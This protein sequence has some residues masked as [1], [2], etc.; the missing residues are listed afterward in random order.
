[1]AARC[2]QP[3][4]NP[5][6][7]IIRP[8]SAH[9]VEGLPQAE[10]IAS[11]DAMFCA[12]HAGKVHCWGQRGRPAGVQTIPLPRAA[13]RIGVGYE[14]ACALTDDE[15]LWCWGL[16]EGGQLGTGRVARSNRPVRADALR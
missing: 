14:H 10:A 6:T 15:H 9:P 16:D 12:L 11:A 3:E 7:P 2:F 1:M 4:N 5:G 13:K 8:T